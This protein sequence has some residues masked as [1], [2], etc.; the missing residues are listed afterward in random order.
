MKVATN[1]KCDSK[2]I[3]KSEKC[4]DFRKWFH[5]DCYV[6]LVIIALFRWVNFL[7]FELLT[8]EICKN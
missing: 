7:S 2:K 6:F 5:D 1:R 4:V 3:Q 8:G